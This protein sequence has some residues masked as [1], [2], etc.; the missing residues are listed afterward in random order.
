MGV[1]NQ[2]NP[3]ETASAET[4]VNIDGLMG[5]SPDLWTENRVLTHFAS[6]NVKLP[7]VNV[8]EMHARLNASH[9]FF[10]E[11]KNAYGATCKVWVTDVMLFRNYPDV[12]N[13]AKE[14]FVRA[15][16]R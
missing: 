1:A 10:C 15:V 2:S 9:K 14:R 7:L 5:L 12:Y 11:F 8:L 4:V 6:S 3:T 16:N 13:E